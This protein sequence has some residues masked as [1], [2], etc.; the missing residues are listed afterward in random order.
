MTLEYV[1]RYG[2][3]IAYTAPPGN[4]ETLRTFKLRVY[5]ALHI[6]EAAKREKSRNED[7]YIRTHNGYMCGKPTHG[8]GVGGNHIHLVHRGT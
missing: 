4:D 6:M 1:C 7:N 2:L 8:L 5:N 3:D